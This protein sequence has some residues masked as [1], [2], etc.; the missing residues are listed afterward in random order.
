MWSY[1]VLKEI[2]RILRLYHDSVSDFSL[3]DSWYSIDNTPQQFEVIC[4]NDFAIYNIIFN[5]ERPI[6]NIDFDVA[7]P[8]PRLWNIAYSLYT[9]SP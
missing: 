1:D 7:G 4:H 3:D 9:S 2:G 5:Y 8:G 6:G